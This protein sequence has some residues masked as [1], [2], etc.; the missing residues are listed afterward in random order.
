MLHW[1]CKVYNTGLFE[2][3]SVD[4]PALKSIVLGNYA[5]CESQV[6]ILESFALFFCNLCIDLS[7]LSSISLGKFSLQGIYDDE[8]CSLTLQSCLFPSFSF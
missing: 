1:S 3:D 7:N 4:L 8:L 2:G 6:I 5:F